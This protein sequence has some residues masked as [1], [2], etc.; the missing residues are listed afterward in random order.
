MNLFPAIKNAIEAAL[1]T[2]VEKVS[3][4]S[5]G[6]INIARLIE[7]PKGNFFVKINDS[8]QS[9]KM[10]KTEASGLRLLAQSGVIGIPEVIAQ[11]TTS[12]TA[13]LVL[14]YIAP[15]APSKVFWEDFGRSLATLHKQTSDHFGLDHDNFIGSL[16]QSNTPKPDTITFL[17]EERLRPQLK[18]AIQS[19]QLNNQ[20]LQN[21]ESLFNKLPQLIPD[22]LPALL[23]GDL[24]SGNFLCSNT[25]K[26]ILIDPAISFAHREMD[27]AMSR[28][29]GGFSGR[30]YDA[31]AETFP[32][33]PGLEDR[34]GIYQL[35]YLLVHVNLFGRGYVG[36]VRTVLSRYL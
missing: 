4:I 21:F 22:E 32:T 17:I 7:T 8:P 15:G 34:L 16:P 29:F 18:L 13:W 26:P 6:D 19:G 35:Y 14:E 33:E 24:W 23:H 2:S 10:L 20:D 30:F 5:G 9:A 1:G 11:G 28:L 27:L 31:Y 25:G 36:Q 12:G 3:P